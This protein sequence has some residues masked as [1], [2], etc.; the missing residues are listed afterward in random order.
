ML[1]RYIE[2]AFRCKF[3]VENCEKRAFHRLS[4]RYSGRRVPLY[5]DNNTETLPPQNDFWKGV[6]IGGMA[7]M[8]LATYA[9]YITDSQSKEAKKDTPLLKPSSEKQTA[10]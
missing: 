6:L 9:W 1:I 2:I 8:V 3:S 5:M 7:G 10:A 4:N